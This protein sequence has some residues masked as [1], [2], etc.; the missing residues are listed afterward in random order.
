MNRMVCYIWKD[1]KYFV[2]DPKALFLSLIF[3]LI[4]ILLVVYVYPPQGEEESRDFNFALVS[5]EDPEGLSWELISYW[6]EGLEEP[7]LLNLSYEEALVKLNSEEIQGFLWIPSEFSS[8]VYEGKDTYM[9]V[10]TNP[11]N[12]LG[13]LAALRLSRGL[14]NQISY[15]QN[16]VKAI[17]YQRDISVE[18]LL[19]QLRENYNLE[20]IPAVVRPAE[21]T[22]HNVGPVIP[23]N[24]INW[25]LP[26]FFTMF[27]FLAVVLNAVD[28]VKERES[29]ILER[30][31][32]DGNNPGVLISAKFI[33]NFFKGMLQAFILWGVGIVFFNLYPGPSLMNLAWVS[34]AFIAAASG[35][36]LL[37]ATKTK[38]VSQAFTWGVLISLVMAPLGGC[39]WPQYYMPPWMS[40]LG[41]LTPHYW[42]NEAFYNLFYSAAD[43]RTIMPA[44][45]VLTIYT[46]VLI[47]YS[48]KKCKF[49]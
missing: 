36:S 19:N 7:P 48:V 6:E 24:R 45:L 33:S 41:R 37:I 38:G 44:V 8:R 18:N 46:V 10:Y 15:L 26:A 1:V 30:L 9:Q 5:A 40:V 17:Q 21:I 16:L 42:A 28:F 35:F 43:F 32:I 34:A 31:L 23:V 13:R 47:I 4:L 11:A 2:V 20:G 27:S 14:A 39:W 25:A 29:H 49:V 3:P 22:L 12:I